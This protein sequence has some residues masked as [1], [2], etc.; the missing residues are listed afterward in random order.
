MG[1]KEFLDPFHLE[2]ACKIQ[3]VEAL[4]A[5]VV[6]QLSGRILILLI[7]SITQGTLRWLWKHLFDTY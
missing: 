4:W 6:T 7:L 5:Y 3:R 1:E 2:P